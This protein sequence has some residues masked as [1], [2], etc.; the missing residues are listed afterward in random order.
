MPARQT[1]LRYGCGCGVGVR[2]AG[3]VY[4]AAPSSPVPGLSRQ[5]GT[6][7]PAISTRNS[8]STCTGRP[9][10]SNWT[11]AGKEAAALEEKKSAVAAAA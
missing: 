7:K 6:R 10:A 4:A 1:P 2:P 3:G 9:K 11:R 5:S 8:W